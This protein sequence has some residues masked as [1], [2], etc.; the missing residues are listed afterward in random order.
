MRM[1]LL[2]FWLLVVNCLGAQAQVAVIAHK[3]VPIN[4]ASAATVL[5]IYSLGVKQWSN[6]S[7]VVVVNLKGSGNTVATFYK[8][9]GTPVLEMKKLWMRMQ[10]SGEAKAPI[11]MNTEEEVVEKVASTRG[12][13]GFVSADRVTTEVKVIA[14]IK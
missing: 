2:G 8:F 3:S 7:T 5:E 13:V 9:I 1:R 4:T 12:A 14:T 11:S 6:E 10:L